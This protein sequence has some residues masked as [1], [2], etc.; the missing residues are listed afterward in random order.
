M[1]LVTV[2][3]DR[4]ARRIRAAGASYTPHYKS[5]NWIR[6]HEGEHFDD[7]QLALILD[8]VSDFRAPH[9]LTLTGTKLTDDSFA[10]FAT[11]SNINVIVLADMDIT[12]VGFRYLGDLDG[13]EYISISNCPN[14][15]E[16]A[17]RDVQIANPVLKIVR[18]EKK[19][20]E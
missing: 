2:Y 1:S 5:G 13:L 16:R 19:L 12:D 11:A 17:I 18:D 6:P 8:A 14:I 7:D 15:S 9:M 3:R 20:K 4:V 10:G